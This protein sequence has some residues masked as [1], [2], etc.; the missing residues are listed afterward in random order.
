M[1]DAFGD[2]PL[3]IAVVEGYSD[4]MRMLCLGADA[5]ET[6]QNDDGDMALDLIGENCSSEMEKF[7]QGYPALK[8]GMQ[9][10]KETKREENTHCNPC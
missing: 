4:L 1:Q 10:L 8:K 2:T 3:M 9:I 7:L 5:D 6:L